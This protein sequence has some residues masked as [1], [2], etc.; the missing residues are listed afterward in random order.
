MYG[1][2]RICN[3]SDVIKSMFKEKSK[4]TISWR[5]LE[6]IKF[7]DSTPFRPCKVILEQQNNCAWFIAH[8]YETTVETYP[9]I[10]IIPNDSC[11]EVG[12][13]HQ[14]LQVKWFEGDQAPPQLELTDTD[15]DTEKNKDEIEWDK[16]K[17]NE[18][19][20]NNKN[21]SL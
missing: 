19:S 6:I 14:Y 4:P 3:I 1:F 17:A 2:K 11:W 18:F 13:N 15:I 8:L 20:C 12:E 21:D 5:P 10:N 7:I 16:D 9:A